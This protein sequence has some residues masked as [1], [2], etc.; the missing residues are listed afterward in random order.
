MGLGALFDTNK[1]LEQNGKVF[2]YG[3]GTS[4]TCA[5][6]GGANKAYT[7][8]IE[9]EAKRLGASGLKRLTVEQSRE[10]DMRAYAHTV[11]KGWA[12]EI[13]PGEPVGECTPANVL[14]VFERLPDFFSD[15]QGKC[16]EEEN[17]RAER[18]QEA[19]LD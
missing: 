19:V 15:L 6:A 17:Y 9:R 10:I 4:V 18:A 2:D 11:V 14:A 8:Y 12:G 3:D 16:S 7:R 5:R 13:Y 1:D